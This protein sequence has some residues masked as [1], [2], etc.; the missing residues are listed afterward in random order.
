MLRVNG[1]PAGA[2]CHELEL[3]PCACRLAHPRG[4]LVVR[5]R[6]SPRGAGSSNVLARLDT[7]SAPGPLHGPHPH[8]DLMNTDLSRILRLSVLPLALAAAGCAGSDPAPGPEPDAHY[9]AGPFTVQPGEE[10]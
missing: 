8:E 3:C 10:L 2:R 7:C 5:G 9:E 1:A 4:L 6:A